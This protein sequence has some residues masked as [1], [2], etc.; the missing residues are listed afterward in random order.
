MTIP[1]RGISEQHLVASA[2]RHHDQMPTGIQ[3]GGK[4]DNHRSALIGELEKLIKC[5]A[6]VPTRSKPE[7]GHG[8]PDAAIV[9][10]PFVWRDFA[11][12]RLD[13]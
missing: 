8:A 11:Y 10:E 3:P 9:Q 6:V 13:L 4:A 2:A 12:A 1:D 7:V 5:A